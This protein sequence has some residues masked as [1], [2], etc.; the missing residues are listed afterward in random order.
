LCEADPDKRVNP[1]DTAELV[2]TGVGKG[3]YVPVVKNVIL[4]AVPHLGHDF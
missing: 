3:M 2:Q 1:K 4:V